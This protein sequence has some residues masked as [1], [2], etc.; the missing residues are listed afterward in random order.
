M[1]AS[2]GNQ[3]WKL[4]SKHGRDKIFQSPEIL[5][6]AAC[7]YFEVTDKRIWEKIE[8][9]GK[10]A[11]MCKV[12]IK[13]PYTI[14]GLTIFLDIDLKT[15][16]NY[17]NKES[18]KDFF[19]IIAQIERIIYTQ[20]FEGASVGIFNQSIIARDLGL[21]DTQEVS[22]KINVDFSN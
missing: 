1:A 4:R 14:Y 18:Y 2:E 15:W 10:D 17:K 19:P 22:G 20:K 8:Y 7:E 9:H 5:W 16:N 3:F 21:R 13:P 12:P 11:K 6:E